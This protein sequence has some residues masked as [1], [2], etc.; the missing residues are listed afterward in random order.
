M[1]LGGYK[2]ISCKRAHCPFW[3]SE[4]SIFLWP[5]RCTLSKGDLIAKGSS[6]SWAGEGAD[7]K[8]PLPGQFRVSEESS[9]PKGLLF[10]EDGQT[11]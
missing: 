4:V 2:V 10:Q 9:G 7:R 11:F 8:R 3:F 6:Q 5:L 1:E